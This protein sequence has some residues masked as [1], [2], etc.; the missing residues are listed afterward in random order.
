[1]EQSFGEKSFHP[2]DFSVYYSGIDF[3]R[4]DVW[5]VFKRK[6]PQQIA[7]LCYH[8][9]M[10]ISEPTKELGVGSCY[11]EDE[12]DI[13]VDAGVAREKIKT[14]FTKLY[15]G[16]LETCKQS[17]HENLQKMKDTEMFKQTVDDNRYAWIFQDNIA[18]FDARILAIDDSNYPVILSCGARAFIFAEENKQDKYSAGQT[19][20]DIEGYRLWARDTSVFTQ[21]K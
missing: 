21:E 18:N 4:V 6:L 13:L 10:T 20:T 5:N 12:I 9:P 14:L 11:L 2:S 17:Y 1:M 16:Y 8:K 19:P 15:D 7:M 3:S